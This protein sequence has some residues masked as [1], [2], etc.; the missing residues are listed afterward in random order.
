M[1]DTEELLARLRKLE[2]DNE[3]TQKQLQDVGNRLDELDR[4]CESIRRRLE[5]A[6]VPAIRE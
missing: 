2:S 4:I 5:A 1:I 3:Q 6:G